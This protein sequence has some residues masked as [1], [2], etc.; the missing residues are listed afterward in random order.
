MADEKETLDARAAFRL[1]SEVLTEWKQ[2]AEEGGY[3]N[4]SDFLRAAVDGRQTTGIATP[5][6]RKRKQ[7]KL[8]AANGCDPQLIAHLARLGN[9]LNQVARAL[10]ECRKS[11]S[12]VELA[13]V[14]AVLTSIEQQA[15]QLF[16]KLPPPPSETRSPE[17]VER[18]RA[19]AAKARGAK[20]AH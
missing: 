7:P 12:V 18:M 6:R 19:K 10:N 14:L 17:T 13:E 11:G 1:P 16:P 5:D 4:L 8:A 2:K 20:D 3:R 15:S 9:N